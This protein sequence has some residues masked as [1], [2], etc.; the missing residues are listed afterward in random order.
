MGFHTCIA[1]NDIATAAII[2]IISSDN[3]LQLPGI[4]VGFSNSCFLVFFSSQRIFLSLII[5]TGVVLKGWRGKAFCCF[6]GVIFGK[7][8]YPHNHPHSY[9]Y[10]SND[11]PT[12]S[13]VTFCVTI[14]KRIFFLIPLESITRD[15]R[16]C[17]N[18]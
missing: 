2:I 4:A 15:K 16:T 17:G 13:F 3:P 6:V 1:A 12:V 9:V 10:A 7:S 8:Y 5:S 11:S 14:F 18:E